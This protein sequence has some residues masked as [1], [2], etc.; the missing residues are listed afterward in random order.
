[1][2]QPQLGRRDWSQRGYRSN[3]YHYNL[4]TA[5]TFLELAGYGSLGEIVRHLYQAL[6]NETEQGYLWE[7]EINTTFV[8]WRAAMVRALSISSS[9][10]AVS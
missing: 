4:K 2:A 7:R 5:L 10:Q 3:S 8:P 6:E 1:M 9:K